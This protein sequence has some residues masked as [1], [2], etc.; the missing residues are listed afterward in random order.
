MPVNRKESVGET[1][2]VQEYA[3]EGETEVDEVVGKFIERR[4]SYNISIHL[5]FFI[6]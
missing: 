6:S 1:E 5:G 3:D 2:A 4:K